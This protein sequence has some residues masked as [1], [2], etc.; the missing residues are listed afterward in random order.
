VKASYRKPSGAWI[1]RELETI[2]DGVFM[3]SFVADEAG[4]WIVKAEGR[5]STLFAFVFVEG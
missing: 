2:E 1:T 4:A 3:N 5:R